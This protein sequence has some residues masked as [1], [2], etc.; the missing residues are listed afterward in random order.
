[1]V[2]SLRTSLPVEILHE[3]VFYL[4]RYILKSF[5][6]FQPHPLGKIASY[7]Y[8]SKL[9]LYLGILGLPLRYMGH[10]PQGS[11]DE[12]VM[13]HNRRS[14]DILTT[15]VES[16]FGKRIQKLRVYA[17]CSRSENHTEVLELQMGESV[18]SL[19]FQFPHYSGL[20][21]CSYLPSP[22]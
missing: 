4:P 17:A 3:I 6:V 16:D 5:L 1:M 11:D 21:A 19:A 10:E 12:L 22:S 20:Q 15:I 8:F 13:W 9:S 7:V 18:C 14:H 2:S